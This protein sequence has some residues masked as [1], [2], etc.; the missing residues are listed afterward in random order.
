MKFTAGGSQGPPAFTQIAG[1]TRSNRVRPGKPNKRRKHTTVK[2]PHGQ[3]LVA[4]A[5]IG[6][7]A[8]TT[9]ILRADQAAV[10]GEEAEE[11]ELAKKLSNPV[12]NLISVPFQ[13]NWDFGIGPANAMKFTLNIQPVIPV[14]L[15]DD[16]NVIIRT[17]L[18][19]I[20]AE[21]PIKGGG[22]HSGL[23]DTT[24][25]FFFSPKEPVGGW[26]IGAG[27]VG[28]YPT[29]TD[30]ALGA[31]KFGIGP[32]VVVLKQEKGWTYGFLGNHIWSVAGDEDRAYVSS[33]F[34][35][36]FV[37]YTTKKH[38]TYAV[39]T[40][41]T[42]NWHDAEWT[43]PINI[44][45]AQLL[46]IGKMPVQFQFGPRVYVVRS[47]KPVAGADWG[48]RFAVTLLFPK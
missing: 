9:S 26:I 8:F 4:A 16:Y 29:A 7:L 18:P 20:Y 39:N 23:G 35:Q 34:L 44:T 37:T 21:S 38:T 1:R 27:P 11:A 28:Y 15:N 3:I 5:L 6:A 42:Y 33:T 43:V 12:A 14:S 45:A 46:K 17:I 22:D 2:P 31:E 36:P 25:S 41:S 24:Q 30:N 48:L 10:A 47:D 32:T 13:N 19:V 40:E